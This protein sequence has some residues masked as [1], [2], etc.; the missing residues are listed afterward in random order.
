[1]LTKVTTTMINELPFVSAADIGLV[2]N[3]N[4]KRA[5]NTAAIQAFWAA[6]GSYLEFPSQY[7]DGA[8]SVTYYFESWTLPAQ[9]TTTRCSGGIRPDNPVILDFAPTGSTAIVVDVN[10]QRHSRIQGFSIKTASAGKNGCT[11]AN[12][13]IYLADCQ[14]NGFDYGLILTQSYGASYERLTFVGRTAVGAGL[15]LDMN[16]SGFMSINN[17]MSIVAVYFNYGILF[18]NTDDTGVC[19]GNTFTSITLENNALS[20]FRGINQSYNNQFTGV[21]TEWA[22]AN[23]AR[24]IYYTGTSDQSDIWMSFYRGNTVAGNATPVVLGKK[25]TLIA[26]GSNQMPYLI[27][28]P[29]NEPQPANFDSLPQVRSYTQG[30]GGFVPVVVSTDYDG[31][32]NRWF[33][34]WNKSGS[35]SGS[36]VDLCTVNDDLADSGWHSIIYVK[37]Y[38]L[39]NGS[40]Y[41]ICQGVAQSTGNTTSNTIVSAMATVGLSGGTI[42]AGT[43]AWTAATGASTLRYTPTGDTTLI[44]CICVSR[45][46]DNITPK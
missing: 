27:V 32:G 40:D 6:D 8:S 3:D 13:G 14:F 35:S 19:G 39:G 12:G 24:D 25:T 7:F 23:T 10:A 1:M 9:F 21:W 38:E 2:P 43:L 33:I 15:K 34:T 30:S 4:T 26:N 20:A 41:I 5:A 44:E 17:F 16:S 22:G 36:P 29:G 37:V 28:T 45:K 31:A 46:A 11:V 18:D 42:I